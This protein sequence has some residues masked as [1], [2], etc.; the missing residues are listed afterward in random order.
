[1][2]V[3]NGVIDFG[4]VGVEYMQVFA[5]MEG[6]VRKDGQADCGMSERLKFR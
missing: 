3:V 4:E 2:R 5:F 1:M 6:L